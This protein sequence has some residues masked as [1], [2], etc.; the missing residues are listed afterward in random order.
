MKKMI[1]IVLLCCSVKAAAHCGR[2]EREYYNECP[3]RQGEQRRAYHQTLSSYP[4]VL[5]E[6]RYDR[7]ISLGG[8][9]I[10]TL[11]IAAEG[12]NYRGGEFELY[13]NGDFVRNFIVPGRDPIYRTA[14]D[15]PVHTIE[16]Y[17]RNGS[18]RI[19]SV[20]AFFE[21]GRGATGTGG[22]FWYD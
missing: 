1:A 20:K 8:D 21:H 15:R 19:L 10:K 16:L 17:R 18:I 14:I 5:N 12:T 2:Y 4:F 6:Y 22:N 7:H 13:V 11:T 9:Y 3:D